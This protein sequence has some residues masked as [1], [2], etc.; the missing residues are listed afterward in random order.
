MELLQNV[1]EKL[2]LCGGP[3][4]LSN[5][6]FY[7]LLGVVKGVENEEGPRS[8]WSEGLFRESD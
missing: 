2:S 6:V 1:A 7:L 4:Y 8:D 5:P 3:E